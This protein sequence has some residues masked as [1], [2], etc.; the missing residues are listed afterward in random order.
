[1]LK[2]ILIA[3]AAVALAG[4]PAQA[5]LLGGV[6]GAERRCRRN[7]RRYRQRHA[8]RSPNSA[9]AGIARRI[10]LDR[11]Q[12]DGHG[13]E[14]HLRC[15]QCRRQGNEIGNVGLAGVVTAGNGKPPSWRNGAGN[16]AGTITG[17]ANAGGNAAGS[18]SG[19]G[20]GA[21]NL[22]LNGA[23][24]GGNAAGSLAGTSVGAL[25]S[26]ANGSGSASGSANANTNG[27]NGSVSI[28]ANG[29][30]NASRQQAFRPR[31]E[32]NSR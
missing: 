32:T 6:T 23:L 3:G 9:A 1:M 24:N 28:I 4:T 19:G 5:Q 15:G 26:S 14:Q 18:V 21:G 11:Q 2:F 29:S 25:G 31:L 13:Y 7:A 20:N 17:M 27:N 8:S 12:C 16:L 30:G 22:G 10:G